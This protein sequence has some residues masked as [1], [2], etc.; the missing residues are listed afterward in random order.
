[1]SEEPVDP[2]QSK[3]TINGKVCRSPKEA[4]TNLIT[5]L[6][7]SDMEKRKKIFNIPYFVAGSYLRVTFADPASGTGRNS[8]TGIC[9]A[10]ANKG[11]GSVFTLRNVMQGVGVEKMFELYSPGLIEIQVIYKTCNTLVLSIWKFLLLM[12]FLFYF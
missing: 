3:V 6:E 5:F 7:W 1:M 9:I 2:T 8:F 12:L 4:N 10:R 11:L